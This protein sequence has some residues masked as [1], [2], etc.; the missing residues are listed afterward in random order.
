MAVCHRTKRGIER[1][2]EIRFQH[3][4]QEN[5][6]RRRRRRKGKQEEEKG[7]QEETVNSP[8]KE[9]EQ[10]EG[11]FDFL[12][13]K[14]PVELPMGPEDS[15]F[16]DW[17][18]I[19]RVAHAQFALSMICSC[20][21]LVSLTYTGFSFLRF[22]SS[23]WA[24]YILCTAYTGLKAARHRNYAH[25]VAYT[26]MVCFQTV[27][28]MSSLCWLF[29]SLYVIDYHLLTK[30]SYY[31]PVS[32]LILVMMLGEVAALM[33]T[34]FTGVFGL[35]TCCRGFGR[36]MDHFDRMVTETRYTP[37]PQITI[38]SIV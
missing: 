31:G 21:L 10:K 28:Y 7:K 38:R 13:G 19:G 29:Y 14:P 1:K 34:V 30:G 6:T 12:R 9:E 5:R 16:M 22:T 20:C 17:N 15:N 23:A 33:G 24:T 27:V 8:R 18:A 11:N 25:L 36:M 37:Q 3:G 4:S 2:N 26:G 32:N 35:L